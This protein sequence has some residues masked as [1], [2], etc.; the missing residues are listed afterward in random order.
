MPLRLVMLLLLLLLS[1]FSFVGRSST[2]RLCFPSATIA[3]DAK[4]GRAPHRAMTVSIAKTRTVNPTVSYL[5]RDQELA[6]GLGSVDSWHQE[7]Q[8]K[9]EQPKE[10]KEA[11]CCLQRGSSHNCTEL[12]CAAWVTRM[13]S[14]GFSSR[15]GS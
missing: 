11:N 4:G 15:H 7:R 6:G 9:Q 1:S 5:L 14:R 2:Q 8:E 10:R 13:K 3:H 12:S